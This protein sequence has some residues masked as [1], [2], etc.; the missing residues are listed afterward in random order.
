MGN[1]MSIIF[2]LVFLGSCQLKNSSTHDQK[3]VVLTFDDA[4]KSH[5]TFVAPL[6]QELGFGATFF[7]S[8]RWMQDSV[9]FMNWEDIGALHKMGFEIGN[10][11]WSH[12][13]FSLPENTARLEGELGLVD[14]QL[15]W[16]GIPKPV[17]FAYCGN[18]FAPET[19]NKLQSLGY[20]YARQGMQP[21]V[22]YGE[23]QAGPLFDPEKH[24]PLLI[25]SA[26]DA[27]PEWTLD[28]FKKVVD[29]A[30]N[31]E[32]AVLQFH[33]VPDKAHEWVTTDPEL[34]RECMQYLKEEGFQVIA[35]NDLQPYLPEV[36]PDDPLLEYTH[37]S[38]QEKIQKLAP[39][40]MAT[41]D[42]FDF[43]AQ[44]MFVDHQYSAAEGRMVTGL[45]T[46][47][48]S[49]IIDSYATVNSTGSGSEGKLKIRPYPGG[50]HPRIGFLDGAMDPLRGTKFSVF[51]PDDPG[52][53]VV[54]D[55]PEAIF[56]NLGLTFLA[57]RHFPTI[58]DY[59]F[60]AIDNVDWQTR[61]DGSLINT[62][63][64]PNGISFGAL[65]TPQ[66]NSVN[67]ELWFYNGTDQ[68]L[69][70]LKTQ[71][72]VMLK[73][74]EDYNQ[75]TNDNKQFAPNTA[76]VKSKQPDKWMLTSWENTFNPWGNDDVPCIHTDPQ[77]DACAPGDT[78]RLKG[79]LWFHQGADV[80]HLMK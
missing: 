42:N 41:R 51:L 23:M 24:H 36:L 19:V 33:G 39:E 79:K 9:N 61:P 15:H 62:W 38:N 49:T 46:E 66:K 54:V 20:K 50:R 52:Q 71:V 80:S 76:A 53:Y 16:Q 70:S 5:T 75:L 77:F 78:V 57:H 72:C 32:I 67:M 43:W 13:D 63:T 25:P 1:L 37:T 58:W 65:A 29:R 73:G 48:I 34:F 55:L 10:H 26:G 22:S 45:A 69:D 3:I 47:E 8:Y 18:W 56:S 6:L 12:L 60:K 74:A 68:K 21:E 31:G 27:Y 14:L 7:M 44:N 28:H 17:S 30:G 64:L 59:Q 35:M 4:V 40:V 11:S 2:L